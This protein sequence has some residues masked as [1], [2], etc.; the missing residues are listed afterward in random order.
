[1]PGQQFVKEHAQRIN[2]AC[3]GNGVTPH[4]LRAGVLQRHR[5]NVGSGD[6][7]RLVEIGSEEL[8]DAEIQQAGNPFFGYENVC[9]LEIAMND[10]FFVSVM[11]RGADG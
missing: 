9:R 8:G 3:S 7:R 11:H 5:P 6:Q 1:M 2:I 4:L 10:L